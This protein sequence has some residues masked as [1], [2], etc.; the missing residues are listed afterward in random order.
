MARF[1]SIFVSHGAPTLAVDQNEAHAF[2]KGLG[3]SIGRPKAIL[4]VSAHWMT[5][6]PSLS[7]A[8]HPETIHDFGGFPDFMYELKYHAPGA[9]AVATRA[10]ELLRA[11]G[12][13][14]SLHPSRGLDHGA[15]V[16]LMLMYPDADIPVVQLS[17][18]P[19]LS[20]EHHWRM[21]EALRPLRDEGVLILGSGSATH[22]LR[23]AFLFK[24]DDPT[25]DYVLEFEQWLVDAMTHGRKDDLLH[26]IERAPHAERAHP[27]NDHF[28]PLLVTAGAGDAAARAALIHHSIT[29]VVLAMDAFAYA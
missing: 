7:L 9:P 12:I 19:K 20:P 10:A 14:I 25:P 11:A 2:L 27:T 15:W 6:V 3:A 24:A 23:E 26:Y 4:V 22:N 13:D 21:G 5:A 29:W 16:P 18:Q 1:P 8:E 28:Y 17:I